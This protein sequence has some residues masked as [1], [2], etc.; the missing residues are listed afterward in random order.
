[1]LKWIFN[2]RGLFPFDSGVEKFMYDEDA[3]VNQR[4]T[5]GQINV[6]TWNLY[7][8]GVFCFFFGGGT[9]ILLAHDFNHTM[10]R[11]KEV[12]EL[13]GDLTLG[14]RVSSAMLCGAAAHTVGVLSSLLFTKMNFW[15][16]FFSGAILEKIARM[17]LVLD[18]KSGN[19]SRFDLAGW[20]F[21]CLFS[22]VP[23]FTSFSSAII[24]VSVAALFNF[25]SFDL[26]FFARHI[27]LFLRYQALHSFFLIL[28]DCT[29]ATLFI[30]KLLDP[31][32]MKEVHLPVD[33]SLEGFDIPIPRNSQ[34]LGFLDRALPRDLDSAILGTPDGHA[35]CLLNDIERYLCNAA[36]MP[37]ILPDNSQMLPANARNE[38]V[39]MLREA[40][41]SIHED[42]R[43]EIIR[44]D[45]LLQALTNDQLTALCLFTMNG[46]IMLY[47]VVNAPF[48]NRNRNM[49]A[50]VAQLDN[51][52]PYLKIALSAVR[53]L[54]TNTPKP[55]LYRGIKATN[56]PGMVDKWNNYKT[57]YIPGR[58][59]TFCPL[60]SVTENQRTAIEFCGDCP[61]KQIFVFKGVSC[62]ANISNLSHYP[63][64]CEYLWEPPMVFT[65]DC[66]KME[67]GILV[68]ELTYVPLA[69]ANHSYK[70]NLRYW[71]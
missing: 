47:R 64:E 46:P 26:D 57:F 6:R 35:P 17:I 34:L 25:H 60:S 39:E 45:P 51:I 38:L 15:A 27:E 44:N 52:A 61:H 68:V 18:L 62:A 22:Q 42:W 11:L 56:M 43:A 30:H 71:N 48:Q 13:M 69:T 16:S 20:S 12:P 24:E 63:T 37:T 23:L 55:R 54:N 31:F 50:S 2:Q 66:A 32:L 21:V 14:H 8:V 70:Q 1:M 65:V 5:P 3:R 33:L 41:E 40:R 58:R 19:F 10:K 28:G 29:G 9:S 7:N 49:E 67:N 4:R 36:L 53:A 59:L